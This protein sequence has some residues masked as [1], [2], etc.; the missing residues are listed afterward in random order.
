L[1]AYRKKLGKLF[2]VTGVGYV[3]QL[4]VPFAGVPDQTPNLIGA[5]L[6]A[7]LLLA[8]VTETIAYVNIAALFSRAKEAAKRG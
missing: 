2:F 1:F 4:F 5:A 6:L 8:L 3:T 7:M